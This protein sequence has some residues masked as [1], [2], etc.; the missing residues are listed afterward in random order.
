MITVV[1][2]CTLLKRKIDLSMALNGA[3]G[4][5]VAITAEPLAPAVWQAA[6][7]GSIGGVIIFVTTPLLESLRID[8]VV[9][10]IPAHLFC[11]IW[12]TMAVPITNGDASFVGQAVGV[13]ANAAFV[14]TVSMAIWF[15]LKVV[16][17]IRASADDEDKGLDDSEVGAPAWPDFSERSIHPAE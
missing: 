12:G 4:G 6:M 10:A 11:G 15:F 3:I 9:G 7:I 16:I 2:L 5:L 14:F 17:G 1:T 8:D 13:G